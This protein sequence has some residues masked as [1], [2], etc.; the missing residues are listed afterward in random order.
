MAGHG[1]ITA[2]EATTG[3]VIGGQFHLTAKVFSSLSVVPDLVFLNACHVG[4]IPNR[5]LTGDQPRGG[6]RGRVAP[7]HRRAGGHRRGMGGQRPRGQGLRDHPVLRAARRPPPGRGGLRRPAGG[8]AGGAH[9]AHVGR[10]P[11]L[12]RS[13]LPARG[14]ARGVAPAPAADDGR[15][16]PAHPAP[17]RL[18]QRPG[19]V[20]GS[21]A[22]RDDDRPRPPAPAPPRDGARDGLRRRA[23]RPGRGPRRPRRVR[24]GRAAPPAGP[25]PRRSGGPAP[26]HGAD[27]QHARPLGPRPGAP[28]PQHVRPGAARASTRPSAGCSRP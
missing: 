23:G 7:R 14:P 26:G 9:V 8:Q 25:A 1:E 10:V 24:P 4:Q 3:M 19:A 22:G 5:D 16:A 11:V 15:A 20:A 21:D 12:R 17:R 28:R 18:G 6:E 27:G 2:D 13:R